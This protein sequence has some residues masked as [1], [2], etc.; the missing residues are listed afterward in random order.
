MAVVVGKDGASDIFVG[1]ADGTGAFTKIASGGLNMHPTFG[2]DG[3]LAYVSTRS[4]APQI[5]V[6]ARRVTKRGSFNMAPTWCRDPDG[7]KVVFMGRD[8][9]TWDVLSVDPAGGLGAM[10]RLTQ[11]EGDN[12]YPACS[13]D[14]RTIAF[15]STRGGLF[16]MD[17]R[18][19]HQQAIAATPIGESLRWEG[20]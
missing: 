15:F 16:V 8:G 3:Q 17:P 20:N 10:R 14:G 12:T 9:A 5:Y 19:N 2:P 13:P 4:G 6:D 11:G 1:D 18:G 7:L